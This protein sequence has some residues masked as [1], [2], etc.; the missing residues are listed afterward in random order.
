MGKM[1]VGSICLTDLNEQ[2]KVPHSAFNRGKNKKAYAD[3]VIWVNDE[4]DQYGNNVSIQLNSKKEKRE[5]EP[6]VYIG[7]AKSLTQSA[8]EPVNEQ[9][10]NE[11]ED[12]LPF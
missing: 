1:Y 12:D 4:P 5:S 8:P 3:I 7:N 11:P 10:N 9:P 6:K 2:A